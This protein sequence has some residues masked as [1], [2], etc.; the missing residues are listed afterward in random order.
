[1]SII[2]LLLALNE[3][4]KNEPF[5]NLINIERLNND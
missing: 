1:M 3:N 5:K 2:Y 4:A